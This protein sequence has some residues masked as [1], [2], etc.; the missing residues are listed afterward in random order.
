MSKV[1]S[2]PAIFLAIFLAIVILL[3]PLYL[4]AI[5]EVGWIVLHVFLTIW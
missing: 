5:G 3:N 4:Q 1:Y 2:L